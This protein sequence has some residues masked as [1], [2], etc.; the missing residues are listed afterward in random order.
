VRRPPDDRNPGAWQ[1]SHVHPT[2]NEE[3]ILCPGLFDG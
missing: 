2:T 3:T 1:F